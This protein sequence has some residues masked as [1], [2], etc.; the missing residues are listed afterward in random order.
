MEID[1]KNLAKLATENDV[2]MTD[3]MMQHDI[4]PLNMCAIILARMVWLSRLGDFQDDFLK[5]LES[6]KYSITVEDDTKG[7][8][9]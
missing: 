5:L 8:L 2:Q 6:P 4:H 3:W 7:P 1:D 9:H